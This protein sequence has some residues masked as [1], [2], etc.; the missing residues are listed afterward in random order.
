[1]LR[2]D[3][4]P[5]GHW[6]FIMR[7]VLIAAATLLATGVA[8]A[9]VTTL[10]DPLHGQCLAGCT[11]NGTNTPIASN[12]PV[13]FG[14]T[15]SPA[16]Q[17]GTQFIDFLVPDIAQPLPGFPGI[18]IDLHG[19]NTL[20]GNAQLFSLTPWTSGFL[21]TYLGISASPSQPIGAYLPASLAI[22]GAQGA[23]VNGFFVFQADIG[24]QTI[25]GNNTSFTAYDANKGAQGMYIVSFLATEGGFVATA[26]SGALFETGSG[27]TINPLIPPAVPEPSTWAMMLLGFAG[28]AY[29]FRNRRRVVGLA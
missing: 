2:R 9:Q 1:M 27:N 16:P 24:T 25:G 29:A 4:M 3:G 19:T 11:D 20:V 17:T 22:L 15:I 5:Q 10:N 14:F 7:R 23:G 28:L 21:D 12:P 18:D 6:R 13:G 26:N 8:Q